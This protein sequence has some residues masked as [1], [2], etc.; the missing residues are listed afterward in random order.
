MRIL[1]GISCFGATIYQGLTLLNN[2]QSKETLRKNTEVYYPGNFTTPMIIVCSD[3]PNRDPSL[4]LFFMDAQ[5]NISGLLPNV[6]TYKTIFKVNI[7]SINLGLIII[8]F[9]GVCN[10]IESFTIPNDSVVVTPTLYFNSSLKLMIY[11]LF[12]G[13][14][15]FVS[16]YHPTESIEPKIVTGAAFF[17]FNV[18]TKVTSLLPDH[19]ECLTVGTNFVSVSSGH[20]E[21]EMWYARIKCTNLRLFNVLSFQ[22]H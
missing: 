9:K 22:C 20:R 8:L 18:N 1:I 19:H 7:S 16:I 13:Q 10:I 2:F 11:S 3:P 5:I 12:P 4:D 6:K 17:K 14:K 15:M 21:Y